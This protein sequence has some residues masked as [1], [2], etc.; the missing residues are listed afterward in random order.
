MKSPDTKILKARTIVVKD[1]GFGVTGV[2][3]AP[4]RVALSRRTARSSDGRSRHGETARPMV[5]A[6][7]TAAIGDLLDER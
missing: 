5:E 2:A 7:A 3:L 1:S 6:G 4:A